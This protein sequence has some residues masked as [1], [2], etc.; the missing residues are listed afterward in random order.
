MAYRP[1]AKTEA[2]RA[3]T[4][5][6]LLQAARQ[7]VARGGFA[8]LQVSAVAEEAG[9]ATG[10][11]YRHFDGKSQLAVEVFSAVSQG[12]VDAMA[13]TLGTE[14]L[15]A[16]LRSWCARAQAAPV[17]ARALL[18][19]PVGPEVEAAR[20]R[21][22]SSYAELLAAHLADEI[23]ASRLPPQDARVAAAGIVGALGEVVLGPHGAPDPEHIVSF[24]LSAIGASP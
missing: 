20:L 3:A 21:Y 13:R 16:A 9:V 14:G 1:T 23:A 22:R 17:L 11:V 18:S 15:A 2:R 7:R 5:A 10:T 19:E 8:L 6:A 4:R 12:E 24:C